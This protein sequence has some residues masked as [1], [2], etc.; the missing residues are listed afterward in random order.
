MA[1]RSTSNDDGSTTYTV[2]QKANEE[3]TKLRYDAMKHLTTLSTGS[4]LLIVTFLEKLF[5]TPK[6]KALIALALISFILSIITAYIAMV[7]L[8]TLVVRLR[9]LRVE[10]YVIATYVSSIAIFLLGIISLV[11]FALA[12]ILR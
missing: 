8:A 6:W 11:V 3:G 7:Q 1:T 9:D 4:I 2:R 12:N 5:A 10:K